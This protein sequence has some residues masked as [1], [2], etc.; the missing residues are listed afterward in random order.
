[1]SGRGHRAVRLD[2]IQ[3][4]G[5]L[6]CAYLAWD[7][8]RDQLAQHCVEPARQPRAVSAQVAMAFGPH[9]HHRRVIFGRHLLDRRRAQ[10]RDGHRAGVVGIVL[11]RRAGRQQPHPGRQLGLHIHDTLA[12]GHQLLGQQIT[13]A[14]GALDRPGALG[15]RSSPHQETLDLAG[16]GAHP[17]LAQRRFG[18]V[19]SRRCMRPLVRID[20]DHHCHEPLLGRRAR[21]PWRACLISDRRRSRLFRATPRRDPTGRAPRSEARPT[22]AGRRFVSQ[23]VR[24]SR[25]Y[26]PAATSRWII[27]QTVRSRFVVVPRS[28]ERCSF[29]VRPPRQICRSVRGVLRVDADG[30]RTKRQLALWVKRGVDQALSLAP[31]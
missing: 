31:K 3:Q 26:E 6:S 8:A 10:G 5:G 22:T 21:G 1:M 13:Q 7:A 4:S 18:R 2:L 9:L 12:R 17:Q 15:E 25:R 30:V 27:N 19:D 16:A 23:P 28:L 20:T 14:A 24:I 11:V 29:T